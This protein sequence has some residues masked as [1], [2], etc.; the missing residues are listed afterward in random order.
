MFLLVEIIGILK[1]KVLEKCSYE[2]VW[3][4]KKSLTW[5]FDLKFICAKL[6]KCD[7]FEFSYAI[8]HNKIYRVYTNLEYD[9]YTPLHHFLGAEL[10]Q[11]LL[12]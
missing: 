9:P 2:F 6:R 1:R 11:K 4:V 8:T 3:G 10:S 12:I 7:N 5:S